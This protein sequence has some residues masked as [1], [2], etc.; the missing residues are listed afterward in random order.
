MH[1]DYEN[2]RQE[3]TYSAYSVDLHHFWKKIFYS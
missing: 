1:L 3:H 2:L